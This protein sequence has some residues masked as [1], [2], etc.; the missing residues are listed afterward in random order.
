LIDNGGYVRIGYHGSSRLASLNV[1]QTKQV[2]TALY[3][4]S[5][6][7]EDCVYD[8]PVDFFSF[9]LI[10]YELLV[11]DYVFQPTLHRWF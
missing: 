2:G 3:M 8:E 11:G 10:V 9:A 1:T 5:E 7:H 4:A 6:M